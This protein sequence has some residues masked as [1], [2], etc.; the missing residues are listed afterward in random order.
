M[1]SLVPQFIRL[2]QK[3]NLIADHQ[4]ILIAVSGGV[5]SLV[6]S[7]TLS[8]YKLAGHNL[9]ELHAVYVKIPQVELSKEQC[10][11]IADT[12]IAWHIP[13]QIING[14]VPVNNNFACYVCARER[15]KQL[16]LY[17]VKNQY[18]AIA[19]G[20][21]LDDYLETGLMNLLYHGCLES[22]APVQS[23]LDNRVR[24]IR[25][26]LNIP[27]KHLLANAKNNSI[28]AISPPCIYQPYNQRHNVRDTMCILTNQNRYFRANLRSVINHW[29]NWEI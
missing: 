19:Y 11:K 22:L 15:R 2:N 26:V 23:M 1:A 6:L 28:I 5:D 24:I 14:K 21:N 10:E 8:E 3:Y 27:K 13:L 20:H 12:L 4:K 25:P 18:D 29:N 16:F 7:R 17:A 9:I